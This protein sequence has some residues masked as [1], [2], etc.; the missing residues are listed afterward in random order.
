MFSIQLPLFI[1]C[2]LCFCFLYFSPLSLTFLFFL[3]WSLDW[4]SNLGT[5]F[6]SPFWPLYNTS[7]QH[8]FLKSNVNWNYSVFFKNMIKCAT[9]KILQKKG[10]L[11][12]YPSYGKLHLVH[13]SQ[14]DTCKFFSHSCPCF[15]RADPVPFLLPSWFLCLPPHCEDN[16]SL[17]LTLGVTSCRRI[18]SRAKVYS[19]LW[20]H[21][22]F[23]ILYCLIPRNN[24]TKQNIL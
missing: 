7:A 14:K 22:Y 16:V 19:D 4:F 24:L 21:E 12:S 20:D 6:G 15:Y 23:Q 17:K 9:R 8:V 11:D 10:G 3:S 13:P 1:R 2:N 18:Y 5:A